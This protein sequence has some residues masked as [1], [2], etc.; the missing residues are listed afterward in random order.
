MNTFQ[1]LPI[2]LLRPFVDRIW[3]WENTGSNMVQLPTLLPGTG[4]ELYFHYREPFQYET[5]HNRIEAC[6]L[7]H[8]FCF[9]HRPIQLLPSSNIGFIAVRFKIGMVHR[10]TKIPGEEL[11]DRVLS[12]EEIW[13]A[14][15]SAL[16][17][18]LAYASTLDKRLSLIQTFLTKHLM[19]EP[20]DYV[21]ENA[22]T[23]L[24]R[25]HAS[26]SVQSLADSLHLG[27]RQLERRFK[28]LSGQSPTEVRSLSRFHHTI[29][30][31][32]L[33]ASTAPLDTALANGYYDQAHF[34]HN[35]QQLT[36]TT[37]NR[38]L[39]DARTKTHFYNKSSHT[40]GNIRTPN[41]PI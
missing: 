26:I 8:L 4:A 17:R 18:H 2:P 10:F 22:M 9:R 6:N 39:K 41:H 32:V 5:K 29:R 24:Y 30:T 25:H 19:S 15:G 36:N 3:G 16:V 12:T 7:G 28:A 11:L 37:P 35:F 27:R 20:L 34:I 23:T 21:V 13:G 33:D 14:S 38:Y 1:V 40:G 31:L